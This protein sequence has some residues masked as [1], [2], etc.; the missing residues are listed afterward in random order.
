ML[1]R[2]GARLRFQLPRAALVSVGTHSDGHSCTVID[3]LTPEDPV[4]PHPAPI[5]CAAVLAAVKDKPSVAAEGAAIL[6]R[7]STRTALDVRGRDEGRAQ[8]GAEPRKMTKKAKRR[9]A[10]GGCTSH[11]PFPQRVG[12][13]E[14]D[15]DTAPIRKRDFARTINRALNQSE[16]G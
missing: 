13:R 8:R 12:C 14:A 3:G 7:R 15:F 1:K 16:C 5:K 11:F 4:Q 6:D 9:R 10:A 2:L